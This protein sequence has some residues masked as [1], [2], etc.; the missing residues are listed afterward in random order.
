MHWISMAMP[1]SQDMSKMA[2]SYFD[3]WVRTIA[4]N[5]P[6][7][8]IGQQSLLV[9][10]ACISERT[11]LQVMQPVRAFGVPLRPDFL[12]GTPPSEHCLGSF[13]L[14]SGI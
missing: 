10:R 8:V 2:M 14:V 4:F 13:E 3:I 5:V 7:S 1:E 12:G 11:H 6:D 9:S